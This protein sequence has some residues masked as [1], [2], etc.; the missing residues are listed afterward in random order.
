MP[1]TH[2]RSRQRADS[3]EHGQHQAMA[4]GFL[5]SF[6]HETLWRLK[7]PP[8]TYFDHEIFRPPEHRSQAVRKTSIAH[9]FHRWK[10]QRLP[11]ALTEDALH[12]ARSLF[13]IGPRY[14]KPHIRALKTPMSWLERYLA[15]LALQYALHYKLHTYLSLCTRLHIRALVSSLHASL[16]WGICYG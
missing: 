5:K 16:F 2:C 8:L 4:C 9:R 13:Q 1:E 12:F 10:A 15:F 14:R 11:V 6:E 7:N 3:G